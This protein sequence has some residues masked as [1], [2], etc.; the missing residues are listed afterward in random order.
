MQ[1][2]AFGLK[3]VSIGGFGDEGGDGL[4]RCRA[5][6]QF[7]EGA[8]GGQACFLREKG[9]VGEGIGSAGQQVG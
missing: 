8:K 9:S 4:G 5:V 3:V 7:P 2:G 1:Q 6:N